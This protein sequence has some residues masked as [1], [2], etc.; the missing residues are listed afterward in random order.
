M[1]QTGV[2]FTDLKR[3]QFQLPRLWRELEAAGEPTGLPGLAPPRLRPFLTRTFESSSVRVYRFLER[4][5]AAARSA[6]RRLT[7]LRST[8]AARSS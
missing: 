7:R 1:A 5:F 6:E 8:S 3:L 2:P 4:A